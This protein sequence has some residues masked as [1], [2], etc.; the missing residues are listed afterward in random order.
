MCMKK[1]KFNTLVLLLICVSQTALT[2]NPSM[3]EKIEGLLIGSASGDAAGG[4]AGTIT[5]DTRFKIIFF[6]TLQTFAQSALDFR[7]ELPEKYKDNYDKWIPEIE[8]ATRWVLG[9]R[10]DA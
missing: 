5:D 3:E 9:E 10:E 4:P 6:N 2:Q 1:L 8:Y 7:G